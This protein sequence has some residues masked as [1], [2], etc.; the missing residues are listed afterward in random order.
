MLSDEQIDRYSRQIILTG[1]GGRG[2]E[3][4]LRGT[5]VLYGLG[6]LAEWI[7]TY[8]ARAGVGRLGLQRAGLDLRGCAPDCETE[9]I[10]G[11]QLPPGDPCVMVVTDLPDRERWQ[12]L[13]H[14][15]VHWRCP[16]VWSH[17]SGDKAF[18]ATFGGGHAGSACVEC[19]ADQIPSDV[20]A[21]SSSS[22]LAPATLLWCAGNAS[23][24]ATRGLLLEEAPT[25]LLISFDSGCGAIQMRRLLKRS[26]C[27]FCPA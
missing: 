21:S 6:K 12:E 3:R 26:G 20:P 19:V 13:Q 9:A 24:E 15:I 23:L 22:D 27:P 10:D 4:L 8:L 18:V 2:Q 5:V 1:V 25:A 11:I 14:R 7:A 17:A 16:V